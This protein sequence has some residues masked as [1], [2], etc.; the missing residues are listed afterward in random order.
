MAPE[1]ATPQDATEDQFV[2][3]IDP[4]WTDENE[5]VQPPPEFV[6]GGW[7]V[8]PDGSTGRFHPNPG[9]RPSEPGLPT[10][11]VDATLQ[12]VA[13]GEAGGDELLA[14]M[15]DIYFGLAIDE[16]GV[17]IVAPAP[18]DVPSLLVTTAVRHRTR[19]DASSWLDVTIEQLTEALPGEGIDVLLNPG[20]PA[21]MRVLAGALKR[22]VASTA[23]PAVVSG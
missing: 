15:P 16:D 17:A 9:Y 11:P 23:D 1:R 5:D 19:V 20:A 8:E 7:Y 13:Q 21:S 18:D 10:D 12:L 6:V 2:L 4:G 22:F 3:V 14:A